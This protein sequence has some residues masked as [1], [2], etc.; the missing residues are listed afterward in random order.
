LVI[1][2]G[3]AE[4]AEYIIRWIAWA[5]QNPSKR[6]EVALVLIGI[7]GIG[8]GTLVRILERIFGAHTFQVTSKD[9][10]VGRFNGHLQ[11][12]ILFI[13][14]EAY[15]GGDKRCVGRLQGMI[16][17]PTLA[18]ERK[19][20]DIYS[21]PNC[22]HIVMLAEP[23]WVIP[24]GKFE[25][26]YAAF[27]VSRAMQGKREYFRS[28][29]N[30]IEGDGAAAMFYDLSRMELGDWHPREIDPVRSSVALQ[31]QQIR[32][33]PPLEQWYFLLLQD[34][35]IPDAL[36]KRPNTA[37]TFSLMSDIR[38]RIPRLKF[39]LT[40]VMLR[41]FLIDEDDTLGIAC[42]KYRSSTGNGWSFPPLSSCRE[43]WEL[44]YGTI[45]W[46][47]DVVEWMKK[48]KFTE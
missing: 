10:V 37:Y 2:G 32:S 14:D 45:A 29:Y 22:L 20:I 1:A 40:E 42:S 4:Y 12:C 24:A 30:E 38:E 27:A 19:G 43:A 17:E 11:D 47:P 28:L 39:D 25:R 3:N 46:D 36:A 41:N 7:K 23:G 6:A 15:W 21:S 34:G 18:I 31:D 44:R 9:E 26:R 48:Q 5:I 13:A 35:V 8:K 33:L 16:T